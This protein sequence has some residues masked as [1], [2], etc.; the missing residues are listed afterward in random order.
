MSRHVAA[1]VC[2]AIQTIQDTI[3][4]QLWFPTCINSFAVGYELF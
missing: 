1:V 3:S 2:H 4:D